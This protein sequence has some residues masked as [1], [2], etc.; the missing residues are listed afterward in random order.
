M[1]EQITKRF[2]NFHKYKQLKKIEKIFHLEKVIGHL[3]H[4]FTVFLSFFGVKKQ[5][6]KT[7]L[8]KYYQ[9]SAIIE[10]FVYLKVSFFPS[11]VKK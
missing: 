3:D 11:K 2:V 8:E 1:L 10:T 4:D 7:N 6:P 9:W 5:R